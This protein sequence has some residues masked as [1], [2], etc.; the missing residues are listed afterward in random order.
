MDNYGH[1]IFIRKVLIFMVN[2]NKIKRLC[3]DRKITIASLCEQLGYNHSKLADVE[4]GR[5]S[6]LESDIPKIA[7]TLGVWPEEITDV[8]IYG[9]GNSRFDP[10]KLYN[11]IQIELLV[12]SESNDVPE[13]RLLLDD[14][15]IRIKASSIVF[16]TKD[17]KGGIETALS[18]K[19]AMKDATSHADSSADKY[20]IP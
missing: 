16:S 4:R 14:K 3:K 10:N 17:K 5:S 7:N 11:A 9:S 1:C 20:I 2:I 13:L 12:P 15:A 18:F 8:D 19:I 6:F